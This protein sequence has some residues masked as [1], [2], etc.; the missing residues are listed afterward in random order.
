M[1]HSRLT[2]LFGDNPTL[3]HQFIENILLH[4]PAQ[5]A[6]LQQAVPQNDLPTIRH[7][8]HELKT[9]F[10]YFGEDTLKDLALA[11]EQFDNTID[12]HH[13]DQL[14]QKSAEWLKSLKEKYKC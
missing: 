6:T 12:A 13:I 8:A 5:L 2:A 1:D 14:I 11:I 3:I 4:M 7:I 9:Q 10:A